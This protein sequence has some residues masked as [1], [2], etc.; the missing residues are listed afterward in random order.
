MDN[1]FKVAIILPY[2]GKLPNYFQLWIK[3]AEMNKDF[4][5]LIFTDNTN[6]YTCS[7]NIKW[8]ICEFKDI[9][10]KVQKFF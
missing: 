8:H 1:K 7:E 6:V 9:V 5:F 3:S 10:N 2:F 4:D